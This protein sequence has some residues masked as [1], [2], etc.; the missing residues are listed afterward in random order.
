M[1]RKL[2]IALSLATL[3]GGSALAFANH[4]TPEPGCEAKHQAHRQKKLE[5]FDT[6]KDGKLSDAERAAMRAAWKQRFGEM[7]QRYDVD[8]DGSLSETERAA[9]RKEHAQRV[10][11]KLDQNGDGQLSVD[12]AKCS[13]LSRAFERL[14]ADKSG[15]LSLDE[16]ERGRGFHKRH[17]GGDDQ[18][19]RKVFKQRKVLV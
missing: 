18:A 8:K 12:E 16:I 3:V 13:R 6:D 17:H 10:L 1:N 19:A 4:H 14:D 15:T 7:K 5:R 2:T 9:M 11:G